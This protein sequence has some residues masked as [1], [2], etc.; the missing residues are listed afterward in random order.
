MY[1]SAQQHWTKEEMKE[2]DKYFGQAILDNRNVKE[3]E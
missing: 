1:A 3:P 2:I